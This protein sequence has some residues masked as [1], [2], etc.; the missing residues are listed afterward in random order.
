MKIALSPLMYSY[1]VVRSLFKRE[2]NA[3]SKQLAIAKDQYGNGLGKYIL[4]DL[5]LSKE[6]INLFG[7]IDETISSVVGKNKKNGT[8]SF[9]GRRLD[10]FL[11]IFEANHSIK[12]IDESE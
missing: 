4:N 7:N 9:W 2:F 12:S 10:G 1:G 11:N 3:W 6:S 5:F 8:L